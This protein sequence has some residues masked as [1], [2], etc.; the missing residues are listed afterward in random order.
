MESF[1][2]RHAHSANELPNICAPVRFQRNAYLISARATVR[3]N[4]WDMDVCQDVC[5]CL[6]TKNGKEEQYYSDSSL[7]KQAPAKQIKL[8]LETNTP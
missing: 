2:D 4:V 1:V 6:P 5:V 8:I 7:A 3:V